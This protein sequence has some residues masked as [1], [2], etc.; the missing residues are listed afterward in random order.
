MLFLVRILALSVLTLLMLLS[1]CG[2]S[3]AP[4]ESASPLFDGCLE[5][6]QHQG[7]N[8]TSEGPASIAAKECL[9][10]VKAEY[11]ASQYELRASAFARHQVYSRHLLWFVIWMTGAGILLA[12]VQLVLG[13]RLALRSNRSMTDSSSGKLTP[14]SIY[15]SSSV[16]GV[17]IVALSFGFF[18]LYIRYVYPLNELVS[19]GNG[20]ATLSP[21][22]LGP[23]IPG[24]GHIILENP[25]GPA[26]YAS[27]AASATGAPTVASAPMSSS[28]AGTTHSPKK[29]RGAKS[30]AAQANGHRGECKG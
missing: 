9:S 8:G 10:R 4:M 22:Q 16:T 27:G 29:Q 15:F 11:E 23:K 1:A 21:E 26:G 6:S 17:S 13:Y 2:P 28:N 18:F 12:G 7:K 30:H 25:T 19:T 5:R 20:V 3:N 14:N 24:M